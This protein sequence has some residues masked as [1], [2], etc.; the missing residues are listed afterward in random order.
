M[1]A[2]CL[3]FHYRDE[4]TS[5]QLKAL[6]RQ[7]KSIL[8]GLCFLFFNFYFWALY[9]CKG[10]FELRW[11]NLGEGLIKQASQLQGSNTPTTVNNE[12]ANHQASCRN[13]WLHLSD[14]ESQ[15]SLN[16]M[17]ALQVPCRLVT[18][19]VRVW[20]PPT[21]GEKGGCCDG[22]CTPDTWPP[23]FHTPREVT[24]K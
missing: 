13:G 18:H 24:R 5:I 22:G 12:V 19:K 11:Q 21:Y 6:L 20:R 16:R 2:T 15:K 23:I 10:N 17:Q 14:L 7:L 9:K 1:V 4:F 8:W 3:R